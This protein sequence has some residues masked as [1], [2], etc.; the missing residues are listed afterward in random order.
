MRCNVCEMKAA[1]NRLADVRPPSGWVV[2]CEPSCVVSV[3]AATVYEV[4]TDYLQSLHLLEL[5]FALT[6]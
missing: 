6:Y 1:F 2:L 5:G 3:A 4:R